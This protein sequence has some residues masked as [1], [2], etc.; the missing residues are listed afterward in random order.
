M[1]NEEMKKEVKVKK[2][3]SGVM[4]IARVYLKKTGGI[5]GMLLG[6]L[7]STVGAGAVGGTSFVIASQDPPFTVEV[8]QVEGLVFLIVGLVALVGGIALCY[9]GFKLKRLN[10]ACLILGSCGL[11]IPQIILGMGYDMAA[12]IVAIGIGYPWLATLFLWL[13]G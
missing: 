12:G 4:S 8:Y 7:L 11:I 5:L 1:R 3:P 2:A 13:K 9:V 6:L 10:V